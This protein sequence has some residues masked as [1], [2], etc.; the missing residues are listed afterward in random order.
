M[1]VLG[2]GVDLKLQLLDEVGLFPHVGLTLL[3]LLLVVLLDTRELLDVVLKELILGD[4]H[5]DLLVFSGKLLIQ[6]HY[7]QS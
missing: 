7:D 5:L 4:L 3:K 1:E 2:S 6:V